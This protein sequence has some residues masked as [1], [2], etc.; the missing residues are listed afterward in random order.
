MPIYVVIREYDLAGISLGI[1]LVTSII[2][3]FTWYDHLKKVYPDPVPEPAAM[4]S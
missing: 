4:P 3:K 2:L 1:V